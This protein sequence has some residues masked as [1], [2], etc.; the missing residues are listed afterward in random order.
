MHSRW[1]SGRDTAEETSVNYLFFLW[2]CLNRV[3]SLLEHIFL[4]AVVHTVH[5]FFFRLANR[6]RNK[7]SDQDVEWWS[8]GWK[9]VPQSVFSQPCSSTSQLTQHPPH[10]TD[11]LLLPIGTCHSLLLKHTRLSLRRLSA[12]RP[13]DWQRGQKQRCLDTSMFIQTVKCE[14]LY[15]SRWWKSSGNCSLGRRGGGLSDINSQ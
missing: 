1:K 6:K 14:Q 7:G 5:F 3:L 12:A 8:N 9:S 13:W 15:S 10:P 4:M 2:L 11:F